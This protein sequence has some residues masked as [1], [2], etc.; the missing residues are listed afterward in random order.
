M[1]LLHMNRRFKIAFALIAVICLTTYSAGQTSTFRLARGFNSPVFAAS[2]PGDDDRLFVV[3]QNGAIKIMDLTT[4]VVES[5]PFLTV[6]GLTTGGEKGL[7]GMAFHPNYAE[8]GQLYVYASQPGGRD[9]QS[10]IFEYTATG[11]P[12]TSNI[13][14]AN[15]RRLLMSIEQPFSNHNAGWI[16]F[17]PTASDDAINHL[18]I[19]TGDGG[20]ARDPENN[21]QDITDNLL[22]KI[23]R[24][25]VSGDDF[26]NDDDRNYSVPASN[27]FVGA[28]GDDEIFVYGLRNPWRNSFDRETGDLWIGDVGQGELEE[29]DVVAADSPGGENF[30]WR[31]MEGTDCF[32]PGD[33]R[34]G[35]L[36]CNDASFVDPVYEYGHNSSAFGG[37]SVT[38]GYVYRGPIEELQGDY[39]F[40]DFVTG[41]IW[42]RDPVTGDVANR[43][44]DLEANRGAPN[45]NV[46]SFAED[47]AGN[48]YVL[49][50][51][52]GSIY[53]VDQAPLELE[54]GETTLEQSYHGMI[55]VESGA[56]LVQQASENTLHIR[57]LDVSGTM[58]VTPTVAGTTGQLALVDQP[59]MEVGLLD[60]SGNLEITIPDVAIPAEKGTTDR[61]TVLV[62][63]HVE[64]GFESIELSGDFLTPEESIGFGVFYSTEWVTTEDGQQLDLIAY[65]ALDGD[66]NGDGSVGFD[67]FLTLSNNFGQSGTWADGDMQNGTVDFP[68]FLLL[69][70]NFGMTA[71]AATTES[72]AAVPEPTSALLGS[73]SAF[74]A[75]AFR[76]RRRG[77]T[78]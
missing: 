69:S 64:A 53:R 75:L 27:P 70:R 5:D 6:T 35:N 78:C 32:D 76:R 50:F 22:G 46:A 56:K 16:G 17:D 43:N 2:P 73:L 41:N 48:L 12:M 55:T 42:S 71:T 60:A 8:N 23:L 40:A 45:A 68:D 3:E 34:D 72:L 39:F 13:A 31:V 65:S 59:A 10:R 36:A 66:V 51:S 49:S 19:A 63:D 62:A 54:E 38:G 26:A 74:A 14:D 25:D 52:G 30:G 37:F 24:I 20:S 9:H 47:N 18:Y 1:G 58:A 11:D 57:S 44:D 7:L 61:V 28:E 15:S 67:D 4:G 77:A 21:S 29:I 33:S